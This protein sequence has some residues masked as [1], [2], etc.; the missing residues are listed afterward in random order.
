MRRKKVHEFNPF[1]PKDRARI[2]G[3]IFSDEWVKHN[4]WMGDENE[5][6]MTKADAEKKRLEYKEY[7]DACGT[8]IRMP[9]FEE[10]LENPEVMVEFIFNQPAF[11]PFHPP[12]FFN[13]QDGIPVPKLRKMKAKYEEWKVEQDEK[14][15][16]FHEMLGEKAIRAGRPGVGEAH[17]GWGRSKRKY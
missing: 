16:I 6:A 3:K 14:F 15:A 13:Y 9:T 17:K 10:W 2:E 1:N 12:L 7:V 11:D 4:A 8:K 5:K